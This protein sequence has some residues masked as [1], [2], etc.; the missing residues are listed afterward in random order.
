MSPSFE[1]LRICSIPSVSHVGEAQDRFPLLSDMVQSM[2]F[3][4]GEQVR[5]SLSFN[6]TGW[7]GSY[8]CALAR[9]A[10]RG[11]P[12]RFPADRESSSPPSFQAPFVPSPTTSLI[13]EIALAISP[14][15][16]S[17]TVFALSTKE[18]IA[19]SEAGTARTICGA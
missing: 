3:R 14:S 11:R 4:R 15:I 6:R 17:R 2:S 9:C 12:P 19:P 10:L 13:P 1:V 18:I 8:A 16:R 7:S 5:L